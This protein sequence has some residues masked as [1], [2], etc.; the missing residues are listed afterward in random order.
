MEEIFC[1]GEDC[2]D[3]KCEICTAKHGMHLLITDSFRTH[4]SVS[5][6]GYYSSGGIIHVKNKDGKVEYKCIRKTD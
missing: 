3:K 1:L 5:P 4:E 2:P 6:S